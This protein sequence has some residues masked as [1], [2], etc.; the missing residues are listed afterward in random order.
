VA[1]P[2]G[3]ATASPPA[4]RAPC[5]P[6]GELVERLLEDSVRL[7][8]EHDQAAV[9]EEG[10]DRVDSDRLRLG[11]RARDV[12]L[13]QVGSDRSLCVVEPKLSR[14]RA[15]D[16]WIADVLA[17]FPVGLHESVVRGGVPAPRSCQLGQAESRARVRHHLG[18]RVVAETLSFERRLEALVEALAVT[19]VELGSRDAIGRVLGVEVERQPVDLSVEP[20][21]EPLS[22]ALAEA[23]E[24]SD[25]VRPDD[26][27]VLGHKARVA[28]AEVLAGVARTVP[29][30]TFLRRRFGSRLATQIGLLAEGMVARPEPQLARDD[31]PSRRRGVLHVVTV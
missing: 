21:L 19:P 24:G 20:A 2:G 1:R 13:V 23:A 16:F 6:G 9:E 27:L 29:P 7:R 25:V 8:P 26:D 14:K 28:A 31:N 22:R 18:R 12:I 5:G 4:L 10:G 17:L 3:G 30:G 15:E 11:G